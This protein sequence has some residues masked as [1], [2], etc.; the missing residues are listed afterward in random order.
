MTV[1]LARAAG[2]RYDADRETPP[3][4]DDALH[5]AIWRVYLQARAARVAQAV[6]AQTAR[7]RT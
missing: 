5:R 7:H 4:I 3:R 6:A 2:A 1:D